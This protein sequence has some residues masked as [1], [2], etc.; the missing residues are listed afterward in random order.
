MRSAALWAAARLVRQATV[1]IKRL[2]ACS[3]Q[4]GLAAVAALEGHIGRHDRGLSHV[5]VACRSNYSGN[6]EQR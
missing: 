5:R 6:H 1:S 3:K 2:L 4:E